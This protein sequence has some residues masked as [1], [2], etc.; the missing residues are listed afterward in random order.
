MKNLTTHFT[1]ITKGVSDSRP[2][3]Q[4]IQYNKESGY[5]AATDSHR[6]LYFKSEQIPATYVQNPLTLEFLDGH[7]PNVTRLLSTSGNNVQF[8]PKDITPQFIALLKAMKTDV[9]EIKIQSDILSFH[10]E[11]EGAFFNIGLQNTAPEN[12]VIAANAKYVLQAIQF[13]ADAYK[14]Q[15]KEDITFNY[16]SPVRPFTF[17][18][19]CYDYLTTPVR[20]YN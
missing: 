9:I 8:D 4:G 16:A 20:R 19:S 11:H 12:E 13:V 15:T 1:N 10:K 5:I 6:M 7:Y 17:R 3:L 14:Y 2:I 18:T